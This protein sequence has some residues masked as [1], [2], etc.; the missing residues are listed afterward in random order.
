LSISLEISKGDERV[1]RESLVAA[2]QALQKARGTVLTG[3]SS[4]MDLRKTADEIADLAKALIEDMS[5]RSSES[6]K[7]AQGRK[8]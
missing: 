3:Y 1:F 5:K 4:N 7:K 8:K 2:K 6:G